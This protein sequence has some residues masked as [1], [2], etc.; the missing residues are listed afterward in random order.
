MSNQS[1]GNTQLNENREGFNRRT[2][3]YAYLGRAMRLQLNE[4]RRYRTI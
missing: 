4:K 3:A 2:G 1:N